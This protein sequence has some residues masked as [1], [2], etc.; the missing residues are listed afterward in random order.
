M[1]ALPFCLAGRSATSLSAT[2][3]WI[4]AVAGDGSPWDFNGQ[5]RVISGSHARR[6]AR[7]QRGAELRMENQI[8]DEKRA[9]IAS[10]SKCETGRCQSPGRWFDAPINDRE[11]LTRSRVPLAPFGAVYGK[12]NHERFNC[13]PLSAHSRRQRS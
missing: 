11:T 4:K 1:K 10:D 6:R 13:E 2:D 7:S 5:S 12:R 3:A 9:A 8:G